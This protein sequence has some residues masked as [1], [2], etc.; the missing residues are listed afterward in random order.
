MTPELSAW[1]ALFSMGVTLGVLLLLEALL[2]AWRRRQ[3]RLLRFVPPDSTKPGI[4]LTR[5]G[6]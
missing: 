2:R 1:L 5:R 6:F 3:D 4:F